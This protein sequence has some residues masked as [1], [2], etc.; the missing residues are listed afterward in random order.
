MS[1]A[2]LGLIVNPIAGI[3]GAVGL[4]GSDG[5]SIVRE[6]EARGAVR[7]SSERAAAALAVLHARWPATEPL[8]LLTVTG[9]M[10]ERAARAAGLEPRLVDVAVA[11][12]TT[13][14]DTRR[15]AEAMAA[16]GADLLLF[17]GGDGTARD[18]AAAIATDVPT[19]GIPTGVKMHS[20]VFAT[21]PAAAGAAATDFLRHRPGP[22]E[23]REVLDLDEDAYRRGEVAP[24]LFGYL[25]VPVSRAVQCAK[26]P[27]AASDEDAA[28]AIAADV[29]ER[30]RPG[31][32]YVLGPG[33]TVRAIADALGV[34]KIP[35]GVD[36]V[37]DGALLA[38]DVSRA[39]LVELVRGAPAT[40]VVTPIGGQGFLFGR[41]NQPIDAEVIRLVGTKNV[42]VVASQA[43]LAALEGRPL[44]VDTGDADCD[45]ELS[46]YVAVVTGYRERAVY[47]AR[48]A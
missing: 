3:G 11:E 46:G 48:P 23:E 20:A 17:A 42:I 41:G 31:V 7:L 44:L 35:V 19:L 32:R 45:R 27:S 47:E 40:L 12:E 2:R 22:T 13:A 4:K 43:K 29:V 18:I 15:A 5:T 9:A 36:V 38:A 1:G 39:G 21:S 14:L 10:G 33:T 37:A 26:A 6:A 16:V 34:P 30:M 28:K 24:R 25:R 8:E